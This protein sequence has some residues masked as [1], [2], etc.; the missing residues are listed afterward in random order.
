MEKELKPNFTV[1][2]YIGTFPIS[3]QE[4]LIELRSLIKE[5]A[6]EAQE[7][8]SYQM[9]AYF[10]NRIL[11]YFA[12]YAKHIG[13][14]PGVNAIVAFKDELTSFKTSKGTVQFPL[15]EP[16]PVEL[17]KQII[18]FRVEENSRKK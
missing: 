18:L 17:I 3:T 6:P 9:P 5:I 10:L 8:I 1:D 13:F 11:V 16:L 15:K 7:R 14:Y 12:G 4:K 2:E